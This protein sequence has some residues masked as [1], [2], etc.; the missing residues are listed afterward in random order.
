MPAAKQHRCAAEHP[1]IYKA[2]YAP[3]Y[4]E[5]PLLD[6]KVLQKKCIHKG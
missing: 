5:V 6:R 2:L 1:Q 4:V 3:K